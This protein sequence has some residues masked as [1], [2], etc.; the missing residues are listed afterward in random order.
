MK[1][2]LPAA[3]KKYFWGDDLND[4]T[5]SNHKKYI[6]QTLLEKGSDHAIG[7]L[8][9]QVNKVQIKQML[10]RLKLSKKSMNFWKIYLS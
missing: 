6:V 7:W 8:L 10:P 4:I 2:N 5:W 3:L 1:V 9:N